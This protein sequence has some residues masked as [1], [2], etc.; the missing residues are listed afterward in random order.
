M[1]KP[2]I[3]TMLLSFGRHRSA[4]INDLG[5]HWVFIF[6]SSVCPSY[7]VVSAD[8]LR[9]APT[10]RSSHSLETASSLSS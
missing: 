1:L 2:E 7:L 5:E 10:I 9:T 4:N 8:F 6:L 3:A